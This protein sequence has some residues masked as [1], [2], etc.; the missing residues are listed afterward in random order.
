MHCGMLIVITQSDYCSLFQASPQHLTPHTIGCIIRLVKH[1]TQIPSA[2]LLVRQIS[3]HLL[4]NPALWIHSEPQVKACQVDT[5]FDILQS[6]IKYNM[7]IESQ[8][9]TFMSSNHFHFSFTN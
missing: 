1:F 3:D 2:G 9:T 7:S 4:F 5:V 8:Q 6:H